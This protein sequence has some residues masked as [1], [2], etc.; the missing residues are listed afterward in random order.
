M[1]NDQATERAR[2]LVAERSH[3]DVSDADEAWRRRYAELEEA[4][5]SSYS[6]GV[7]A[8]GSQGPVVKSV[9][10]ASRWSLPHFLVVER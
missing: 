4:W 10:R 2:M 3:A 9:V 1:A 5:N 8:G 6:A 7:S